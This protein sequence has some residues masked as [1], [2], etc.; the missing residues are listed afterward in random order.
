MSSIGGSAYLIINIERL[1][2][3]YLQREF[4]RHD[5]STFPA[6]PRA[7]FRVI[8]QSKNCF[9][10]RLGIAN[11]NEQAIDAV[12]ADLAAAFSVGCDDRPRRRGRLDLT[13]LF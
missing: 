9:C 3:D 8:E 12:P 7:Q 2:N 5:P 4:L 6:Q 13:G 10:Q 1:A 11:R